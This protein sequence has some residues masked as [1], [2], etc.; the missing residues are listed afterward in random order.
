MNKQDFVATMQPAVDYYRNDKFTQDVAKVY[1][2]ELG[3][4]T[5]RELEEAIRGHIRTMKSF[6]QVAHLKPVKEYTGP[7]R[8]PSHYEHPL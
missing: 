8:K 6:P 5:T 7:A 2:E 4:M 1:Y 3:G